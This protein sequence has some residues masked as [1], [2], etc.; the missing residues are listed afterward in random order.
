MD[1][2]YIRQSSSDF[3]KIMAEIKK[4]GGIVS[5]NEKPTTFE[6]VG[7]VPCWGIN[8]FGKACFASEGLF[9]KNG[10]HEIIIID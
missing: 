8:V 1:K 9:I 7:G 10:Y 6:A 3:D 5:G 2:F 4:R